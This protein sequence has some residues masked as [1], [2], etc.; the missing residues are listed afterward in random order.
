MPYV[1]FLRNTTPRGSG[2]SEAWPE[3]ASFPTF[4][5][6]VQRM[7]VFKGMQGYVSNG[8]VI[9][10]ESN[11]VYKKGLQTPILTDGRSP[12]VML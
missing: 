8:S 4:T 7:I 9:L 12:R 10:G 2:L 1:L 6:L 11:K 5:V 3:A